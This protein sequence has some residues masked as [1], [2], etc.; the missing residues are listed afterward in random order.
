[1]FDRGFKAWC[2]RYSISKLTELGIAPHAPLD[3][4]RLAD[5]L[6]VRVWIPSDVPGLSQQSIDVLLFNENST[7]SCCWSAVTLVVA[8]KAVVILNSSHSQRRL[9]SDLT[10]ELSHII[11]D[12]K[13]HETNLTKEG[14]MLL[15]TYD[16]KHEDEADWLSSCLLLP[17]DALVSIKRN[18]SPLDDSA[19]N[20]GVSLKML[21]YRM[22]MSGVNR[23]FGFM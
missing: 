6:E 21:K 13:T 10:H 16:K 1:V 23:Q 12:H 5:N 20:Y 19:K 7:P 15:A 9:A 3:A 11:L 8:G 18:G 2:E 14:V 4:Y 22:A 17:R